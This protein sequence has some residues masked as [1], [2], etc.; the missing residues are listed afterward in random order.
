MR[1]FLKLGNFWSLRSGSVGLL[2]KKG[3]LASLGSGCGIMAGL[4]GKEPVGDVEDANAFV[5][6]FGFAGA[7]DEEFRIGVADF[8]EWGDFTSE[9]F[10][11]G[12]V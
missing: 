5:L 1:L 6:A 9:G 11:F 7:S 10:F 4:V 2:L 8:E 12:K 3:I